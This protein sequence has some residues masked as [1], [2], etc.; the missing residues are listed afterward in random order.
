MYIEFCNGPREIWESGGE[1]WVRVR[2]KD[3]EELRWSDEMRYRL[4]S[5]K[6]NGVK[7]VK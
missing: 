1:I 3:K 7:Q 6:L 2:V 4:I 5:K